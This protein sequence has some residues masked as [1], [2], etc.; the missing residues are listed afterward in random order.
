MLGY[1][2][3][4]VYILDQQQ[5]TRGRKG[6]GSHTQ[7]HLGGIFWGDFG[8]FPAPNHQIDFGALC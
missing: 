1:L 7:T 5:N 2:K 4:N 3:S 8:S 6:L